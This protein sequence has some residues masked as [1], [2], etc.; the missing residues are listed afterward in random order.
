MKAQRERKREAENV[1]MQPE[2]RTS[3][4]IFIAQKK[5]KAHPLL[6]SQ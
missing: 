6:K 1:V 5:K 3:P 2:G 4:F